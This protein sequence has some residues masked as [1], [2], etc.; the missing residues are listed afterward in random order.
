MNSPE[1]TA[2]LRTV[3]AGNDVEHEPSQNSLE[4]TG[5]NFGGMGIR[6]A[7]VTSL[8]RFFLLEKKKSCA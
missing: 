6:R 3:G 7:R 1:L 8:C 4:Q 5:K 2:T